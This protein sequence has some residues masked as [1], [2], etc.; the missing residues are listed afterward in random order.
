MLLEASAKLSIA[1]TP[2]RAPLISGFLRKASPDL[3][4]MLHPE[5]PLPGPMKKGFFPK[6]PVCPQLWSHHQGPSLQQRRLMKSAA[7]LASGTE[8][9]T[10][11][12][13]IGNLNSKENNNQHEET[14]LSQ[15]LPL[16]PLM[17]PAF[18]LARE[19]HTRP[20]RRSKGEE[21]S[22]LEKKLLMNPYGNTCAWSTVLPLLD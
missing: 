16:S 22:D 6:P 13:E 12:D 9:P 14:E 5:Q 17:D 20:K 15:G 3:H 7:E 8:L 1:A 11:L 2:G 4:Y 21:A 10:L 18:R 19:R